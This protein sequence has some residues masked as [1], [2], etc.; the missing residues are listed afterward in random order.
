MSD[1][2]SAPETTLAALAQE[3]DLV[4]VGVDATGAVLDWP[5]NAR[6]L[7][8][9]PPEEIVGR[10]VDS[11]FREELREDLHKRMSRAGDGE[12]H[13]ELAGR[14]G[15]PVPCGIRVFHAAPL[16]A[17]AAATADATRAGGIVLLI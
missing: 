5:A 6:R 9:W 12:W 2:R 11:L 17:A 4:V 3:P 13:V 16:D 14:E 15:N 10:K 7:L 8:G 1:P